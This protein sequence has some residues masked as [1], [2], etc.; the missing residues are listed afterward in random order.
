[1]SNV[2]GPVGPGSNVTWPRRGPVEEGH[3]LEVRIDPGEQGVARSGA[4][5]L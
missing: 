3:P 1:L 4:L 2:S 5:C